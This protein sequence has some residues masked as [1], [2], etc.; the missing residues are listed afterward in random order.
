MSSAAET[1]TDAPS[2]CPDG[3]ERVYEEHFGFAWRNLRRLGVPLASVD[4][5]VQDVFLVVFRRWA[6]FEGRSSVRTWLFGIVLRVARDYRKSASRRAR[7]L[8]FFDDIRV[9]HGPSD[10][11]TEDPHTL[12]ERGEATRLLSELL[13]TLEE[14]RRA[15]FILVELEQ[16][17]VPEAASALGLN[18]NTAYARLRAAR[19]DF[20]AALARHRAHKVWRPRWAE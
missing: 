16:M 9:E 13:G 15:L 12:M 11:D 8:L 2:D 14:N 7:R 3:P 5:A 4:D 6:D 20:E 17:T 18:L 10:P 19:Q 1:V